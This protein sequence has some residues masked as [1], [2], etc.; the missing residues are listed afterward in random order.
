MEGQ[1]NHEAFGCDERTA[2]WIKYSSI[3]NRTLDCSSAFCTPNRADSEVSQ[4]VSLHDLFLP[5]GQV[6]IAWRVWSNSVNIVGFGDRTITHRV[7]GQ[8]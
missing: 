3:E 5:P 6:W 7:K 2:A 4:D 8:T 1:H